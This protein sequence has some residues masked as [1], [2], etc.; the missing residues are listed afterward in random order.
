MSG[1]DALLEWRRK[2]EAGEVEAPE[3][4]ADPIE[5]AARKPKSLKLA[6][7]ARCYQCQGEGEDPGWRQRTRECSV[8]GC[9]LHPHRPYREAL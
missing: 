3:R 4:A 5:R 9:A 7:A 6:I 1:A 2:V 8:T